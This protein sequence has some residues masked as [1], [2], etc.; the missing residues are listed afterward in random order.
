MRAVLIECEPEYLADIRRCMVLML[1]G[2]D[3]RSR[4]SLKARGQ[5]EHDPGPLFQWK[6]A[7]DRMWS[8]PFG[9]TESE[10]KEI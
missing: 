6:S 1:A 2:P 9:L 10:R 8:E 3:E 7:W 5:V 4:E